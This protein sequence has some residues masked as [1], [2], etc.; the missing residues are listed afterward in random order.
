MN[1]A[2]AGCLVAVIALGF[3]AGGLAVAYDGLHIPVIWL[4][5][6]GSIILFFVGS[7]FLPWPDEHEPFHLDVDEE[8]LATGA[9]V[10][11]LDNNTFILSTVEGPRFLVSKYENGKTYVQQIDVNGR[12]IGPY[13]TGSQKE[14]GQLVRHR[15]KQ[16]SR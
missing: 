14:V 5:V 16:R 7:M 12:N 10:E 1:Y 2:G 4:I 9:K 13:M 15:V 6:I 3:A 11:P 8:K